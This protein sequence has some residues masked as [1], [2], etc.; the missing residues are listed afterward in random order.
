MAKVAMHPE[1]K[2]LF[3]ERKNPTHV[4]GDQ[5]HDAM[6]PIMEIGAKVDQQMAVY[7]MHHLNA[8][9]AIHDHDLDPKQERIKQTFRVVQEANTQ[10]IAAGE[11]LADAMTQLER[12]LAE[13]EADVIRQATSEDPPSDTQ[14]VA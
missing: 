10:F 6:R 4:N 2:T 14:D 8:K 9:F 11:R 1:L 13:D 12:Y 3:D 7:R 5:V